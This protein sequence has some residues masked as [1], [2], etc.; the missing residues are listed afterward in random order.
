MEELISVYET[1]ELECEMDKYKDVGRN[2]PC[3][4][5]SGKKFKKCCLS[6]VEQARSEVRAMREDRPPTT[7]NS[8]IDRLMSYA[9]SHR[10][11]AERMSSLNEFLD[12][13]G[14][15]DFD[16]HEE[17]GSPVSLASVFGDWYLFGLKNERGETVADEFARRGEDMDPE[18]REYLEASRAGRFSVWE[19]VEVRLD[20]G[21]KLKDIFR[22]DVLDVREKSATHSLARWDMVGGRVGPVGDHYNLLGGV[23]PVPLENRMDIEEFGWKR[24]LEEVDRG[25]PAGIDHWL[26]RHGYELAIFS[27]ERCMELM[28]MDMPVILTPEGDEMCHCEAHYRVSEPAVAVSALEQREPFQNMGPGAEGWGGGTQAA[29]GPTGTRGKVVFDWEMSPAMEADLRSGEHTGPSQPSIEEMRDALGA[30]VPTA[31][32]SLAIS[33]TTEDGKLFEI[34]RSGYAR[35]FGG[36]EVRED[37]LKFTTMSVQRLDYGKAE[38]ERLLGD[39]ITH[40][41]D[42]IQDQVP[43]LEDAWRESRKPKRGGETGGEAGDESAGGIDPNIARE[44]EAEF[45]EKHYVIWPDTPLPALDG[46]TPRQAARSEPHKHLVNQLLKEM[47]N[48]AEKTARQGKVAYD[49]RRIRDELKIPPE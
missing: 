30:E 27:H 11:S 19:A 47:E 31:A 21:M 37:R 10:S 24:A 18:E 16:E 3:P 4:C 20:E 22:G 43:L 2:E 25:G 26:E 15:K 7:F 6:K 28:R 36:V 9:T 33:G 35:S 14:L 17:T 32:G 45:L 46:M 13:A 5:G 48:R 1:E 23:F 29:G 44:L 42:E 39:N 41:A 8:M 40:L 38:L 49:F 12:A 34:D